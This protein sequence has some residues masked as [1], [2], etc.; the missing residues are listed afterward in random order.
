[1]EQTEMSER[2]GIK[3]YCNF[4]LN[5]YTLTN[6]CSKW[7]HIGLPHFLIHALEKIYYIIP[8]RFQKFWIDS[9]L[10]AFM[11]FKPNIYGFIDMQNKITSINVVGKILR[12]H[13]TSWKHQIF[14]GGQIWANHYYAL[15]SEQLISLQHIFETDWHVNV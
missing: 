3:K 11:I 9:Q 14:V 15:F 2:F 6:E 13:I 12:F 1:M 4:E 10:S 5:I 8:E 7:V